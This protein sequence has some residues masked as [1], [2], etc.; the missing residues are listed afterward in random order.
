MRFISPAKI[1][2]IGPEQVIMREYNSKY[3]LEAEFAAQNIN[4]PDTI[5]RSVVKRQAEF[6]AGRI[7]ARDALHAIHHDDCQIPIGEHRAPV[8]PEG[9]IGAISHTGS[10]A[11]AIVKKQQEN[12]QVG[13]DMEVIIPEEQCDQLQAMLINEEERQ[14]LKQQD[15]PWSTLVT[16]VFSAK[17]SL[18]KAIYPE[19]RQYLE[20]LDSKVISF[21][22][23]AQT[24]SLQMIRHV[25]SV[26]F[27]PRYDVQYRIL[28]NNVVTLLI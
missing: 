12:A 2:N 16:L 23:E 11:I 24:L 9:I 8:W 26:T 20:F 4:M 3:F 5:K 18:F 27:R 13:L 10:A 7:V 19:V 1:L 6:L 21:D 28:D 14:L 15:L 22:S 17:E 25:E